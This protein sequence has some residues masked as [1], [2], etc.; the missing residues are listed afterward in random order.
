METGDKARA[1]LKPLDIV[2][3]G[4]AEIS[5]LHYK[6]TGTQS[7]ADE[8]PLFRWV[9]PMK[10]TFVDGIRVAQPTMRLLVMCLH[11]VF[12]IFVQR[13]LSTGGYSAEYGEALSA[14]YF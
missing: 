13:N 3:T 14:F 8:A 11:E 2:T 10:Q 9:R 5:L 7:V 4:S 1:V 12:T 6:L